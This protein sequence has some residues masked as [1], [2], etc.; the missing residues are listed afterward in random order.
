MT[1]PNIHTIATKIA[2]RLPLIY[3][4]PGKSHRFFRNDRAGIQERSNEATTL[5][6]VDR[7][8]TDE[9]LWALIEKEIG[10]SLEI[11]FVSDHQDSEVL[12]VTENARLLFKSS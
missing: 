2:E 1:F 9:T 7:G 8:R 11:A 10:D 12:R 4:E 6:N 5:Q 3:L